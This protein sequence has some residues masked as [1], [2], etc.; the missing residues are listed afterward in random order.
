MVTGQQMTGEHIGLF[1]SARIQPHA[2]TTKKGVLI[3]TRLDIQDQDVTLNSG[4]FIA[5]VI[6][7][8]LAL[9]MFLQSL[10]VT[11]SQ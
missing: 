11:P 9:G 6:R 8:A 7:V 10:G 3:C 1:Y 5:L 2:R 4:L